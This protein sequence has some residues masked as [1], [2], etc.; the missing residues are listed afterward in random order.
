M[1]GSFTSVPSG[2]NFG[3]GCDHQVM[4]PH[5][6]GLCIPASTVY[7]FRLLVSF[8][9]RTLLTLAQ[10]YSSAWVQSYGYD[11]AGRLANITSPAD[12][13]EYLLGGGSAASPLIK[14]LTF[15]NSAYITNTYDTVGRLAGTFLRNNTDALLN[16]H[17][18][19]VNAGNQRYK[20]TFKAGNFI[21]YTYDDIGQLRSAFGKESGGTT[22]LHE[23]FGYKYD[24]AGNLQVRTNDA[25]EQTFTVNTL[26]QLSTV[27]RSGNI[28]VAGFTTA[29][30]SSVTVKDNANAAAPATIYGDQTYARSG[31]GLNPGNNTFTAVA[32]DSN[33]RGDTN[34]ITVNLPTSASYT[35]DAN[36]N[37][38]SDGARTFDYD[39][40]N[41]LVRISASNYET[42]FIYDGFMR[43][44][45]ALEYKAATNGVQ[46]FVTGAQS[47]STLIRHD[48]DI[49]VGARFSV[50][51]V[52]LVVTELGRWMLSGNSGAHTICLV[53]QREEFQFNAARQA[54]LHHADLAQIM[55]GTGLT[56][57]D[58]SS[59]PAPDSSPL[60]LS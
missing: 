47:L 21:D 30:A 34:S 53:L 9:L 37:L 14:K 29:T 50:G 36:G 40:E 13:F 22:R 56:I 4:S 51:P 39:D 54:L 46:D 31:V 28:T 15:P 38:T 8:L 5:I 20:Q 24:P 17:E 6:S 27:S 23:K 32:T 58:K 11:T 26:N 42:H 57:K 12:Y 48:A 45:L 59:L 25:L 1:G 35:Y 18:Y 3:H 2:S 55:A 60:P 49:W 52:P 19:L 10:P 33:G 7:F 16:S 44:R 43:R 41:Q